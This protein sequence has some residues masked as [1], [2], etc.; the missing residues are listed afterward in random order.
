MIKEF[1]L[2]VNHLVIFYDA[3]QTLITLKKTCHINNPKKR[4]KKILQ[5][6]QKRKE[7]T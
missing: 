7:E 6:Q 2:I 1:W 5:Q 4:G 3:N